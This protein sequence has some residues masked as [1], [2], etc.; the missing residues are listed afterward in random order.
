MGLIVLILIGALP[1]AYA[2]NRAV[3]ESQTT[4]FIAASQQTEAAFAERGMGI[5]PL[6][7]ARGLVTDALKLR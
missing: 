7:T 4:G 3:P 1:T 6:S 2:L 5:V